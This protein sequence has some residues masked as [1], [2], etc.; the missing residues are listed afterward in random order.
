MIPVAAQSHYHSRM[1][2]IFQFMIQH[3]ERQ[4]PD[5][6]LDSEQIT[7]APRTPSRH[8]MN[9]FPALEQRYWQKGPMQQAIYIYSKGSAKGSGM[10]KQVL[11]HCR[12]G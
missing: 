7:I 4:S 9:K 1:Q 11:F 10:F 6:E 3:Y 2:I 5:P 12:F 8:A